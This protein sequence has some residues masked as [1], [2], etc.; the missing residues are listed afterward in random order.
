MAVEIGLTKEQRQEGFWV[1]QNG[2]NIQVWKRN[3][4]VALLLATP[5]IGQKVHEV[6]E[7][8]RKNLR[9]VEEKTGWKAT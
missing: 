9:E 2:N 5:D 6:V 8:R 4:Q 7:R 1:E 3:N